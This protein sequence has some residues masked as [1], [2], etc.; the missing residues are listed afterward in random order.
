MH[1]IVQFQLEQQYG[2]TSEERRE[3]CWVKGNFSSF[4]LTVY[5]TF[6]FVTLSIVVSAITRMDK[7]IVVLSK[8]TL[9]FHSET[10][11]T[12]ADKK[13]FFSW[14]SS[15]VCVCICTVPFP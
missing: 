9:P 5:P 13:G 15:Y 12:E 11:W 10:A 4:H 6:V 2:I 1:R 3:I 7:R 14:I 8:K